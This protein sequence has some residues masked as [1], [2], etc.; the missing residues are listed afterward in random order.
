MSRRGARFVRQVALTTA[1][2]LVFVT[3][4]LAG[5]HPTAPNRPANQP[6]VS[7]APSVRP[8]PLLAAVSLVVTPPVQTSADTVSVDI[9]S[10]NGQVRS[11]QLEGGR[12]AIQV[13]ELVVRP[14]QSVSIRWTGAK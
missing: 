9:R 12:S 13:Q 8:A 6:P 14:G 7:V 4:V 3:P 1:T 10:P 2:A 5:V 11:F